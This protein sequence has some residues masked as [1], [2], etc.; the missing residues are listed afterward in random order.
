MN[1]ANHT[2]LSVIERVNNPVVDPAVLPL[3]QQQLGG[4]V[5]TECDL[6][7]QAGDSLVEPEQVR[8][9]LQYT[10]SLEK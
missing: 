4:L 8:I 6:A 3:L 10:L 9:A 1:M 2:I 7:I 5:R